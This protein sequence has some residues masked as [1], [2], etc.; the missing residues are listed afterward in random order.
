MLV[1]FAGIADDS[2]SRAVKLL[3]ERPASSRARGGRQRSSITVVGED[4]AGFMLGYETGQKLSGDSYVT[5]LY[6]GMSG[7]YHFS[8]WALDAGVPLF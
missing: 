4:V 7:A 5:G 1:A 8:R 2:V 6:L 3:S